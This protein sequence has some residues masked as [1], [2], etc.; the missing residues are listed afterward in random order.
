MRSTSKVY[1]Y[2]FKG[3]KVMKSILVVLI[4]TIAINASK[5]EDA[6][7]NAVRL[8][9]RYAERDYGY[10]ACIRADNNTTRVCGGT[11]W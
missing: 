6:A 10:K 11:K 2:Q 1:L 9:M 8:C 3:D 5:C 7:A 4:V